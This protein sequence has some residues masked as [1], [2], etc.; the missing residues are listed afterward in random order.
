MQ[1]NKLTGMI[2]LAKKAG[3]IIS[4][5]P[6]VCLS[7]SNKPAPVLVLL[8]ETASAGTQKKIRCKTAFYGVRLAVVPLSTGELGNAVGKTGDVAAVAVTDENLA[9]AILRATEST[10]KDEADP[11]APKQ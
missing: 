6:L 4:G 3:K 11:S 8:S 10:G 7:L 9:G 2:G 1:P 5:T